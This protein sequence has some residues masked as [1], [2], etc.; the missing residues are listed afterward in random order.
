M[1]YSNQQLEAELQ[2]IPTE[3]SEVDLPEQLPASSLDPLPEVEE[4]VREYQHYQEQ[5]A[6]LDIGTY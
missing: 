4:F 6:D 3:P 5:T 2:K 1:H